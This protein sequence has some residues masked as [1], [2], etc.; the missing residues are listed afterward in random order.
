MPWLT[1]SFLLQ[2]IQKSG[3]CPIESLLTV[4]CDTLVECVH[5]P[6]SRNKEMDM[7]VVN[8]I[9]VHINPDVIDIKGFNTLDG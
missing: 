4:P 5:I 6:E 8:I 3:I 7:D 9:F 1:S 2:P